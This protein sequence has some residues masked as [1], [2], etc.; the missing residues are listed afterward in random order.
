MRILIVHPSFYVYGGAEYAITKFV[1]Y[2]TEKK[3]EIDILTISINPDVRDDI[4]CNKFIF[5]NNLQELAD[6][7][8]SI[9]LEYNVINFY[10]HPT[11]LMLG[12]KYPSVWYC[13]EPPDVVL[14]GNKLDD[15]DVK[16]VTDNIVSF[17]VADEFNAKRFKDV[18][19]KD[20]KIIPYGVDYEFYS[21]GK[22]D[23][24]LWKTENSFAIL[25][26]AWIHPRKNQLKSLEVVKELKA[27]IPNVKLIL[28]GQ[29]DANYANVLAKYIQDNDLVDNVIIYNGFMNREKLRDLYKSVDVLIHPI[30]GQGGALTPFEAMCARLPVVISKE[31]GCADVIYKN[32]LGY[33]IGYWK[34]H[35]DVETYVN[36]I[37]NIYKGG[38]ECTDDG[39]VYV[40]TNMSWKKYSDALLKVIKETTQ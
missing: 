22:A 24:W 10:N 28:C 38:S 17:V 13:N 14:D 30:K 35:T 7:L 26:S 40:K 32:N 19:S 27:K 39:E 18:Y 2:A 23:R 16:Q 3:H 37:Y 9:Y 33:V 6:K 11:E 5:V 12:T 29:M 36:T 15:K 8:A 21:N 31:A 4:K 1:N 34:G 25:H 20:A